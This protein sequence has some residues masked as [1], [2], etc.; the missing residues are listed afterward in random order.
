MSDFNND[1]KLDIAFCDSEGIGI[2]LGNGDGTFQQ[3][4]YHVI[5]TTGF[6]GAGSFA[7]AVGNINSD[8]KQDLIVSEYANENIPTMA[9]FLGKGDGTF[10]SPQMLNVTA[11][12]PS[13]VAVGDF[14]SDGL[15]DVIFLSGG[16][17]NVVLQQ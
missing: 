6:S 2:M 11:N 12:G 10:Q 7:F 15:L 4:I 3:P 1:R 17:M 8:G 5:D 9:I 13:G 14:N 16:G